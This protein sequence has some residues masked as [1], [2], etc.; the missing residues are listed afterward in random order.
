MKLLSTASSAIY[1][2]F[3]AALIASVSVYAWHNAAELLPSL[4]QRTAA[5]LPAN[6]TIGAGIGSLALMVL[7]E[8]LYPL[9][10]LDAIRIK[11]RDEG[12]VRNAMFTGSISC[13]PYARMVSGIQVT[14]NGYQW[15][16]NAA[17]LYERGQRPE[18]GSVLAIEP[19]LT[20]GTEDS[21]VLEDDWSVVTVDGSH[22]AH[23]EHTVAV[24]ESGPR[25][26]TLA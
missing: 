12:T 17:G 22:A 10:F 20:L 3:I 2:A 13:V 5:T 6:A 26:R 9:V 16:G 8:A 7:L 24:T 19:M 14:G 25:I 23:W 11:V 4:A 1:Y 15:W 18:P 21:V